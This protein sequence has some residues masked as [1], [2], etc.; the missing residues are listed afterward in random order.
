MH[1]ITHIHSFTSSI[2]KPYSRWH[3]IDHMYA[4]IQLAAGEEDALLALLWSLAVHYYIQRIDKLEERKYVIIRV[5][6]VYHS[7]TWCDSE[8]G[9]EKYLLEWANHQ[10][11]DLASTLPEGSSQL[12]TTSIIIIIIV[13]VPSSS[14]SHTAHVIDYE[15]NTS[16]LTN[17]MN[18]LDCVQFQL[19]VIWQRVSVTESFFTLSYAVQSK[20]QLRT[21]HQTIPLTTIDKQWKTHTLWVY[22][23]VLIIWIMMMIWDMRW[24]HFCMTWFFWKRC[25]VNC[26]VKWLITLNDG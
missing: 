17:L 14:T 10:V 22:S 9:L 3:E 25:C 5:L 8:D 11:L 6:H 12:N 4:H 21:V 16:L 24:Y 13:V 15:A 2:D 19:H 1:S 18:W 26:C 20:Y 7:M 23:S